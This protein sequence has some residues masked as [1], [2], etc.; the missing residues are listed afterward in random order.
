MQL[1]GKPR[2]YVRQNDA[3]RCVGPDTE[4]FLQ[5]QLSQDISE[6]SDNESTWSF[7]LNPNG[8]VAVWLRITR[9]AD[10]EYLLDMDGGWGQLALSR[11]ERFKIRVQSEIQITQLH[12]ISILGKG[13]NK[14]RE[15]LTNSGAISDIG[16]K[17]IEGFD[18]LGESAIAPEGCEIGTKEEY[19]FLR[20]SNGVPRMG[21]ELTEDVIPAET[22]LVERSVSFTKGCYTG[23]ELVARLD[24]RGNRVPKHLRRLTTSGSFATGSP[25]EG[26]NGS[27]GTVT[28][29]VES[30][31][32][33]VGLG[34]VSRSFEVPG[35]ATIDGVSVL[36]ESAFT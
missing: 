25:I 19:E 28:S 16:W 12:V 29:C 22:N 3:L 27:V 32:G 26:E 31:T 1:S 36:I 11:L 24:S 35:E 23:Q 13:S 6:L 4:A 7:L 10:G 17:N 15:S 2:V 21:S 18:L 34:Y 8:K 5:G 9:L 20:V 14:L 33:T 30:V